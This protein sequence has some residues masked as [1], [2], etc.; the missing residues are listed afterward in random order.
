MDSKDSV[1]GDIQARVN[2]E[3]SGCGFGVQFRFSVRGFKSQISDFK[4]QYSLFNA[5]GSI[6][7]LSRGA[8]VG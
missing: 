5:C 4:F 7:S 3:N 1:A 6:P 8:T 2:A